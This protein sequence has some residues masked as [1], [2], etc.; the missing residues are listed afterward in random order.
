MVIWTYLVVGQQPSG[1]NAVGDSSLAVEK[2][3]ALADILQAAGE[4]GW[5]L[6]AVSSDGSSGPV[7]IFKRP[8]DIGE[9]ASSDTD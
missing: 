5:E 1:W 8:V 9:D 6:S 3:H 4:K 2:G 7:Y